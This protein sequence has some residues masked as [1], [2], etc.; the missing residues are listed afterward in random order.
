MSHQLDF[1]G[2]TEKLVLLQHFSSGSRSYCA[3]RLTGSTA[4]QG[5]GALDNYWGWVKAIVCNYTVECA[6]KFR[7]LQDTIKGQSDVI[8]FEKLDSQARRGL[9]IGAVTQG[10][11]D[12]TIR[13]SCNKIIHARRVIPQWSDSR[14]KG[15]RFRYW[16]G[17]VEYGGSHGGKKWTVILNVSDWS[18]SMERFLHEFQFSDA[19]HYV[20]QDWY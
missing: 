7:I 10:K 4:D 2:M 19:S 6:V 12:L 11:F 5:D 18:R 17:T 9:S 1:D 3:D 8:A 16:N 13:E 15:R 14:A 20:G